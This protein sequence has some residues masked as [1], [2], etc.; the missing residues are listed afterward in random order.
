ML[1]F[2]EAGARMSVSAD[3][4]RRLVKAGK[5][6]AVYP[7]AR[8]RIL[9][10]ELERYVRLISTPTVL[11]YPNARRQAPGKL[12]RADAAHLLR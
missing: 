2:K 7:S 3:T 9:E 10:S 1:T 8:P 4:V 11:Q 6:Q 12:S 5:L